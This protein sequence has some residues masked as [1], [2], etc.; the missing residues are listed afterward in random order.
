MTID[1]FLDMD[2]MEQAEAIWS[3]ELKGRREEGA[4]RI[5]LYRIDE[6]YVEVYYHIEHGVIKKFRPFDDPL[7]LQRYYL[8]LN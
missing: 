5:L 2:E 1:D 8:N 4:Y 3:G 7:E 6:F